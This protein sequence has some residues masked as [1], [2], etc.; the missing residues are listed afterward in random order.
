MGLNA[1]MPLFRRLLRLLTRA[2]LALL[3]GQAGAFAKQPR[4]IRLPAGNDWRWAVDY[5]ART[6]PAHARQY[7]LLVLEP[8]HARLLAP[9]RRPGALAIGYISLGEVEKRRPFAASL[10]TAGALLA[11]NPHWPDARYADLRHPRWRAEIL[12]RLVPA[13]MARGYNGIFID[14]LDNAEAME[15]ADPIG[16]A[17]MIDAAA[18]LVRAIHDRFPAAIIVIN[19]GYALLPKVADAIDGVLGE[20]MATRWNFATRSYDRLSDDDWQWQAERLRAAK[21]I[22]PALALLTL[23][24]WDPA[25]AAGARALYK[26]ERAAGFVPYVSVLALDRILPEPPR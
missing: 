8:D 19:R 25:D 18:S 20:A 12:D 3:I 16:R 24:Y 10:A 6:D 5:G 15:R 22:N 4:E 23:D 2:G 14:T 17:G 1:D 9:L 11:A 7:D 26:R 21:A 13:I